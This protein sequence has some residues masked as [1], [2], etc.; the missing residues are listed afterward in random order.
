[1]IQVLIVEDDP[2][3]AEIN[4]RYLISNTGFSCAGIARNG[5][6]ALAFLDKVNID[7][8]LLDICMP[9]ENGFSFLKEIR[10]QE[11]QV[12]AIVISAANDM[13]NIKKALRLG[14]MDY[15]IKPFE[16]ERLNFSLNHYKK[17]KELVKRNKVLN[18]DELDRL[19]FLQ[20]EKYSRAELPKG[21]AVKTLQTVVNGIIAMDNPNFTAEELAEKI[22]L[23][24]VSVSKYLKFLS[25]IG[26]VSGQVSY[27]AVGRPLTRY[28]LNDKEKAA[29]FLKMIY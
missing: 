28:V 20:K 22:G 29:P 27:G 10:Q 23:T 19:L 9:E 15:L 18:Q 14:A 17:Q 2:M 26:F 24:R 11:R 21:L 1:M 13:K 16:M 3:V 8:V 7:L 12:D 6:E 5:A 25:E 4:R